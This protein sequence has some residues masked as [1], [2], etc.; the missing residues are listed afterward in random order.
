MWCKEFLWMKFFYEG[1]YLM[2][3]VNHVGL[4]EF[5]FRVKRQTR[6]SL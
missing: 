6:W 3:Y 2:V 1:F 5:C 4:K